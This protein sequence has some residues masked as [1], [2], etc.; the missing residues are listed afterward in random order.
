MNYSL[1]LILRDCQACRW[2]RCAVGSQRLECCDGTKVPHVTR[3]V[4][5]PG[6]SADRSSEPTAIAP[7]SHSDLSTS[8]GYIPPPIDGSPFGVSGPLMTGGCAGGG[9][10]AGIRLRKAGV[11]E[12]D[13]CAMPR[14]PTCDVGANPPAAKLDV[15]PATDAI[16]N[17]AANTSFMMEFLLFI[18]LNSANSVQGRK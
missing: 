5:A 1:P 12:I 17:T 15:D 4:P 14:D 8:T 6:T 10:G 7:P 13:P 2:R 16:A 9:S 11:R 18:P 3:R